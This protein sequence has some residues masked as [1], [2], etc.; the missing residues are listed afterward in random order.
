VQRTLR[1]LARIVRSKNSGPFEITLDVVFDDE[2]IFRKVRSSGALTAETIAGLYRLAPEQVLN[3]EFFHPALA[4]KA[5][6]ARAVSSGSPAE[7]D[8][9]GG[10]QAAPLLAVSVEI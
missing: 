7:T 10:Q 2:A 8:T 4:F 3:C 1:D 6:I 5:T 9:Y